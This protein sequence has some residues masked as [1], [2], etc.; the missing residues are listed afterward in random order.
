MNGGSIGLAGPR[1][2]G[3]TTILRWFCGE[4]S[5]TLRNREVLS[6]LVPAPADYEARDFILYLYY[7]IC[8]R[9]L[10]IKQVDLEQVRWRGN[11][12]HSAQP[13][14]TGRV[15]RLL[16]LY[17]FYFGVLFSLLGLSIA[18]LQSLPRFAKLVE[19]SGGSLVAQNG[20]TARAQDSL[21][22]NPEQP[23]ANQPPDAAGQQQ[24]VQPSKAAGPAST[25]APQTSVEWVRVF[26]AFGA[27]LGLT[28]SRLFYGGVVLLLV[29]F[30]VSLQLRH[31]F[32][33]R[34]SADR[35]AEPG[36]LDNL[37]DPLVADALRRLQMIKFQQSYTEGWSGALKFPLL[38]GGVKRDAALSERP[39]SLP[40]IVASFSSFLERLARDYWVLIGI[41][42]LDKIHPEEKAE[43]FLND[44]KIIFG[45]RGV[46]YL[47]SI[48]ENALSAF[49]RRGLPIRNRDASSVSLPLLLHFWRLAAR[50]CSRVP[51]SYYRVPT[52]A[53]PVIGRALSGN[54]GHRSFGET[55]R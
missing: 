33:R 16:R 8:R 13:L 35:R 26:I 50:P 4:R 38:E 32:E 10:Q 27:A 3:K 34:A 46:F 31:Y 1:G 18:V 37:Q 14:L 20:A 42:E 24:K 2:A 15:F 21:V 45:L 25:A 19:V 53:Q 7:A 44:I 29:Y 43:K 30:G 23:P 55:A 12:A 11:L 48:S 41:D 9:V 5:W 6:V 51:Q 28:A 36:N 52:A 40:E 49:E 17:L 54:C 47:L 39:L 22:S